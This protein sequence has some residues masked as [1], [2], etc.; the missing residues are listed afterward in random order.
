VTYRRA[1]QARFARRLDDEQIA[2][3]RSVIELIDPYE[4]TE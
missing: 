1:V 3:V 4:T 2:A